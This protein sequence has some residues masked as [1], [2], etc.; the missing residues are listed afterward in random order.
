MSKAKGDN[1]PNAAL[2]AKIGQ[3][4][5]V[6]KTGSSISRKPLDGALAEIERKSDGNF[7]NESWKGE[8]LCGTFFQ[9]VECGHAPGVAHESPWSSGSAYFGDTIAYQCDDGYS[10]DSTDSEP[11]RVSTV[12]CEADKSFNAVPGVGGC[13]NTDDG[14]ER[15]GGPFGECKDLLKDYEC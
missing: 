8:E 11:S 12:G 2:V 1:G 14:A 15:A 10:V 4:L 3:D 5:E 7:R 6:A 13:V 9:N